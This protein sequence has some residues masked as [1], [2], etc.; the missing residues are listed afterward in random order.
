MK[1]I[2]V[3]GLTLFLAAGGMF[4]WSCQSTGGVDDGPRISETPPYHPFPQHAASTYA[5]RPKMPSGVSQA[6]MDQKIA[7]LFKEILLNNLIVDEKGPQNRTGFRIVNWH[8]LAWE[9]TEGMSDHSHVTTSESVG[10][11]MLMMAYMAGSEGMLDMKPDEWLFGCTE[12]KEYYD[13]MLRTVLEYPSIIA[14][15][16]FTWQLGG[17]TNRGTKYSE[18]VEDWESDNDGYTGFRIV[19]GVKMAPFT[20]DAQDGDSATDGDMDIIYSLIIADKQWGSNGRYNYL[21]IARKMLGDFWTY[22]VHDKYFTLRLGDWAKL[23]GDKGDDTLAAMQM[24]ATRP[25]DFIID[26]LRVYKAVDPAHD[27][28]KV[29]DATYDVV[30]E[31]IV[32][33]KSEYG[34]NYGLLPDF[35]IRNKD[36]NGWAIPEEFVLEG[37]DGLFAY[38]ACRV[39]WRLGTDYLLYG[40]TAAAGFDLFKDVIKPMDGLA[41]KIAGKGLD[42][43]GPL[44]MDGTGIWNTEDWDTYWDDPPTFPAPFLVT[45]AAN[46]NGSLVNKMWK[47]DGLEEFW[48]DTWGDYIKMIVMLT[49]SGNY[50]KP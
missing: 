19:N 11:G 39:P 21:D 14:P 15:N 46:G 29:I 12:I 26:H 44:E 18:Y 48:C 50:W 8:S 17:Y 1:K 49:A 47:W 30:K 27:W 5:N 2:M 34:K 43:F 45:A 37:D 25:S 16:L 10:Y 40:N 6:Q 9:I 4:F 41:T 32:S 36:N 31:V 33:V 7:D 23:G 13:A 3:F 24:S 22:I 20:R 38:N 42:M 28:Q 35:V